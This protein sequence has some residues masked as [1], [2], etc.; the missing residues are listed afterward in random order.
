MKLEEKISIIVPVYNVEKYIVECIESLIKQTYTNIEIILIN[1]GST[2]NSGEICDNYLKKDSR[3]T[4]IHQV[5]SGLSEARN[6]GIKNSSGNYLMFVDSDDTLMDDACEI[7]Y[8]Y[9]ISEESDIVICELYSKKEEYFSERIKI[10]NMNSEKAIEEILKQKLFDTSAGGKLFKKEIFNEIKFPK[11]KLYEDLR[12]IYKTFEKAKKITYISEKKYFYRKRPNS[13]TTAKFSDKQMD[14]Y[15]ALEEIEK[16]LKSKY[17][18]LLPYLEKRILN[19]NVTM[20]HTISQ[21]NYNN[22]V[23]I[24]MLI[25]KIKKIILKKVLCKD[26]KFKTKFYGVMFSINFFITKQLI[27]LIKKIKEKIIL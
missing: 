20:L 13:I 5:N 11:G 17:P 25:K 10:K 7:L 4:V 3:I 12:T 9:L 23:N 27:L 2:D 8:K 6:V 18:K 22:K 14:L 19:T 16:F 15:F 26:I 21:Q 24:L 1:D